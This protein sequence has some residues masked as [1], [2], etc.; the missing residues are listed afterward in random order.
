MFVLV[1][2][3][4][5]LAIDNSATVPIVE[6]S[7]LR[8]L[9]IFRHLPPPALEGLAHNLVSVESPAG[10]MIMREGDRGDRYYA[11]ADGEVIVSAGGAEVARRARGEGF[12]EI[13]LLRTSRAPRRWSPRRTPGS[14][15]SSGT[16]LSSR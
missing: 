16:I 2:I 9:P 10:S 15:R 5:L 8:S 4:R 6:I 12:G 3:R 11:I 1:F 7:L 14:T 13:A